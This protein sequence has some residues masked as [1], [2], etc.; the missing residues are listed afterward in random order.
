MFTPLLSSSQLIAANHPSALIHSKVYVNCIAEGFDFLKVPKKYKYSDQ[1]LTFHI[2]NSFAQF[3]CFALLL[4][5]RQ[6]AL[7]ITE[8]S[9]IL[10]HL[11]CC[12]RR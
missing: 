11:H 12:C 4:Y 1:V 6:F 7:G 10:P 3:Y 8:P 5:L 2:V 9:S